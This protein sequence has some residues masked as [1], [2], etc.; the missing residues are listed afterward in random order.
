VTKV[1]VGM[2]FTSPA[3][4][5]LEAHYSAAQIRRHGQLALIPLFAWVELPA[6]KGG[7]ETYPRV[8]V[9][10]AMGIELHTKF[11]TPTEPRRY[12]LL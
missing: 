12:Q 1:P 6:R 9:E 7:M 11:L 8:A 3:P 2:S 5:S 4:A 10:R